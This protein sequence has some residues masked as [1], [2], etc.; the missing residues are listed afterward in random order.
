MSRYG[1]L[2]RQYETATSAASKVSYV[3][4]L[5]FG[6]V[7]Q[8]QA[9]PYPDV[10]DTETKDT[11]ESLVD[12]IDKFFNNKVDSVFIDKTSS[13]PDDVMSGLKELGLFGLQIP[14]ELGGLG[15]SNTAY[16]RAIER[17]CLDG[18][19]AVTLLAHQSIGLKGILLNGNDAQKRKYLPRLA[20]G[21][22]VAAFALTEPSTGSDAKSV[23]TKATLGSD[24]KTFYL[25]G[26]KIWISNGGIATIFTVFAQTNVNGQDKV[27]AFI[28]DRG[29]GGLTHGK[30]ENKLGIKGSNTCQV[31]FE[32]T[33]VPIENVLG[34]VGGGFKVA[35]NILNNGRFGLG[36][37]SA[38]MIKYLIKLTSEH[39]L[40]RKQFGRTL[41]EFGLIKEKFAQMTA[42]AYA[43][44]SMVF[45]T[46]QMIDRGDKD[47]H[48]E[49][50]IC[51]VF[52]SEAGFRATNECIQVMGGLGFMANFPYERAMRDARILSIFE[53]TNEI[54]RMLI[55][56][57]G[58]RD[59]GDRLQALQKTVSKGNWSQV[60]IPELSHYLF[61]PAVLGVPNQLE[62]ARDVLTSR[63]KKFG[64]AVRKLIM[65]Y[66]KNIAEEQLHLKRVAN[67]AIDLYALSASLS[68]AARSISDQLPSAEHETR[69]ANLIALQVAKRVDLNTS[70]INTGCQQG[71]KEDRY[72]VEIANDVFKA[73][74]YI[75]PH[76]IRKRE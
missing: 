34:E 37:G 4:G 6:Q 7:N 66:G 75:P 31:F 70:E 74:D 28:V 25:N 13:I 40:T 19:I 18:S 12:S 69:L 60:A 63:T 16:A 50:A 57:T 59:V 35:M 5:F 11:V 30:P 48:V 39:A 15:L 29:F 76:P 65:T 72:L 44:E 26:S 38:S 56:L 46:T 51:K 55:A 71:L 9:F 23:Q 27:T 49:A 58:I 33:P 10:L 64:D 62:D 3:R 41:S 21:E 24:G 47:C 54:L 52:G 20:T 32:S 45:M 22:H 42:D 8:K 53:G 1:Q 61:A 17:I 14:T 36:A 43:L 67:S 2:I 73:G 68:R